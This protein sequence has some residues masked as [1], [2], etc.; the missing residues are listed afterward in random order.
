VLYSVHNTLV[1]Y[2]MIYQI[3]KLRF[4]LRNLTYVLHI[5][6]LKDNKKVIYMVK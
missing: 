3:Y 5:V 4:S 1:T 6:M 2:V